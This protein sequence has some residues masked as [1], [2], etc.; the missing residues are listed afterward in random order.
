M[1]RPDRATAVPGGVRNVGEI[2]GLVV[3]VVIGFAAWA[4][5][6][7]PARCLELITPQEAALPAGASPAFLT[8]GP[9]RRPTI[10]EVS[11]PGSAGL[12]HSPLH[13]KLKFQAFGGAR[14]DPESVVVTYLKTPAIDL[15]QRL[16]P[17][18]SA[19]G[20]DVPDAE[21]PP[22]KH[23]FWIQL[24]D[25]DGRPGGLDFGFEVGQ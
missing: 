10:A 24:K 20:I 16:A 9:T 21:V 8:G 19:D 4:A 11:P 22:G 2:T 23:R 13:F 5:C 7:S 18:I 3:A 1:A 12:V 6:A 17:F 15:T 25:K 14:I